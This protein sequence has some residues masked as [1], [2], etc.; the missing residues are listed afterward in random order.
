MSTPQQPKPAKLIIGMFM[1]E[2]QL[3]KT[4]IDE[5]CKKYGKIDIISKWIEFDFTSYY[6]KEMDGP[7]KRRIVSF[8]KL[9]DQTDIPDIKIFTN[10]LE[11]KL[12]RD[13]M[14]TVN[15]DPG[16]LLPERFVLAT[17]KNFT[18]RIYLDKGIY[19]DLTLIFQ[20]GSFQIL[21]WTY[22]DY[23]HENIHI[24]LEKVRRNYLIALKNLTNK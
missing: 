2:V 18:H 24:F 15:I 8:Q 16:Y 7:L 6:Q 5:L 17:G 13:K 23:A 3:I 10:S 21:P 20:K 12:A 22:P 14:R 19:A 4:V 11:Q 9:I 1:K